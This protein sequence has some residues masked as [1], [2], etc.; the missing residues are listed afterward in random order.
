MR[1]CLN[2]VRKAANCEIILLNNNKEDEKIT[3]NLYLVKESSSQS[4]MQTF[5]RL[6]VVVKNIWLVDFVVR[7]V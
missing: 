7:V 2:V 6:F 1:S 5:S 3:K 4:L